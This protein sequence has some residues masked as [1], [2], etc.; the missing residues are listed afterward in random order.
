MPASKLHSS[1]VVDTGCIGEC[2]GY[3]SVQTEPEEATMIGECINC[4]M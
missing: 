2:T 3:G 4:R 1:P